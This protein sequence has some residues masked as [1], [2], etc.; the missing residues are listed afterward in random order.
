M[1]PKSEEESFL[2][3]I[4]AS[5]DEAIRPTLLRRL[6]MGF[7]TASRFSMKRQ[8]TYG[9]DAIA[10]G[11]KPF[12][13][14]EGSFEA[15]AF[16]NAVHAFLEVLA[17]KL[18]E[19]VGGAA[20]LQ[21]VAGWTPRIA[22]VLRGDGLSPAV[23]ERLVPRVTTALTNMLQDDEGR[24][25]LSPHKQG[26]NELSLNSWND[27]RSSVRL[28]RVFYSG[29]LPTET[30]VGYLWIID[31]K[32]ATHGRE[33]LDEFLAEER[34]KYG[35]QMKTYAQMMRD[36][37]ENGRVRVGLYYPMLPKLVWWEPVTD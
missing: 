29:A 5:A 27:A 13:R 30:G 34:M 15:R 19:G 25:V 4:A 1:F 14:P 33:G 35:E 28:D 23:V 12:E 16:G 26:S 6:P 9:E 8:L 32:T 37:V 22:S 7:R 17:K 31:Y 18:A 11:A 3:D 10:P 2:G 21:E 36:R 24:W 20:V